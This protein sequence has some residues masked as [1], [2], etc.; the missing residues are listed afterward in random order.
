VK[1]GGMVK[2][3]YLAR[4]RT[5]GLAVGL[6]PLLGCCPNSMAQARTERCKVPPEL[7]RK[8]ASHPSANAYDALGS[9]FGQ[10]DRYSCAV[11]A[12]RSSLRLDPKSWQTHSYLGLALLASGKPDKA[13]DELR[14]SL[15]L[16]P[17]QPN[18]HM[19]LGAALS[20]LNQL[21]AAIEE[22][23][24][25]RKADPKSVTALDW[26]SKAFI[27]EG[28]YSAAIALLK[29]RDDDEVLQMNLVIAYSKN[30]DNDEAI[31]LLSQMVKDRPTSAVPH[32]GLATIYTQQNR[33]E[34]AVVEF[35]EALRLDPK[36]DVAQVSYVKVL[37]LLTDFKTA[38]PLAQD[39]LSRH[40]DEFQALYLM[41][42]IDLELGNYEPARA[43]LTR[44]VHLNPNHYD[45]H[46]SLGVVFTKIGQLEPA[47]RELEL[48]VKID[49]SS[50]QA[51]F[52]LAAVLRSLGFQE[53]ARKQLEMYQVSSAERARKDMATTK[54]HQAKEFLQKGNIQRAVD[55]YREAVQ[56]NPNDPQMLLSLALALDRKGDLDGERDALE[57]AIALNSSFFLAHNQLGLIRL[58]TGQTAQAEREFKAA[59]F[60]RPHYAEAQNNLGTLYGQQG[61]DAEAERMF[62]LAIDSNPGYTQA[63]VNLGATLASQSRFGEAE[64]ALQSALQIDRDNKDA[65]QLLTM[66]RAR[67]SRQNAIAK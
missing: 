42:V 9:Y 53:E 52:R 63:F 16:N 12:F 49:P 34:D 30:E 36:N 10:E 15:K 25:V 51:R 55:L 19:T 6:L 48:A 21:D 13:V 50:S 8:I 46:Y 11:S 54:S 24:I 32:A 35:K 7:Q 38:L 44:A 58:Q 59:I 64:T 56:D 26:L 5:S 1:R 22:F 28:R 31:R 43:M 20:Q 40:P 33:L 60:L 4:M 37:V 57:K 45:A 23:N 41:G 18:T 2:L 27:S 3:R 66:I 62:R 29:N 65:Q 14:A 47:M 67:A 39:Y 61:N 17:D